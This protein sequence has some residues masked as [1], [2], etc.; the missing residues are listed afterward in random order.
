[1]EEAK[2]LLK[3]NKLRDFSQKVSRSGKSKN[4]EFS[5]FPQFIPLERVDGEDVV[6]VDADDEQPLL[7]GEFRDT[8]FV[9]DGCHGGIYLFAVVFGEELPEMAHLVQES[10]HIGLRAVGFDLDRDRHLL[11]AEQDVYLHRDF[12]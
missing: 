4:Q 8:F 11:V 9:V 12:F 2:L 6:A 3:I 10:F 5:E 7:V 1:M